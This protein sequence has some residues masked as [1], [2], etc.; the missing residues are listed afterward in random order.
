MHAY[1]YET[2]VRDM[3]T[4]NTHTHIK[5]ERNQEKHLFRFCI[6]CWILKRT[7]ILFSLFIFFFFWAKLNC[8]CCL[9]LVLCVCF[10]ENRT[11]KR[12]IHFF[13]FQ[14]CLYDLKWNEMMII[15]KCYI[16]IICMKK[17]KKKDLN[18]TKNM[19]CIIISETFKTVVCVCE[20]EEKQ[21][22]L[23][24]LILISNP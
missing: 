5:K 6:I 22:H 14:K 17:K 13:L 21:Q 2:L 1:T 24:L 20:L 4:S 19:L 10:K 15:K 3:K 12:Q 18:H 16:I 9:S 11:H 8:C 7:F 23:T